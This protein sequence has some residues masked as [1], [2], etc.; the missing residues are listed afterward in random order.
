[1]APAKCP[2]PDAS[3]RSESDGSPGRRWHRGQRAIDLSIIAGPCR[4]G[5]KRIRLGRAGPSWASRCSLHH[6]AADRSLV[7]R[8]D[9]TE[10]TLGRPTV[11]TVSRKR[12]RDDRDHHP[13]S[14]VRP[15]RS[16]EL[17]PPVC[18]RWAN[19]QCMHICYPSSAMG[20]TQP[21]P[22]A[23]TTLRFHGVERDTPRAGAADSARGPRVRRCIDTM[24][25][26]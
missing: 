24:A 10:I 12:T 3:P 15:S 1:M 7:R 2:S 19:A 9:P 22:D 8:R 25:T 14:V 17:V 21:G 6:T 5:C 26:G 4:A 18:G 20:S 23:G 11:P 16:N 13:R